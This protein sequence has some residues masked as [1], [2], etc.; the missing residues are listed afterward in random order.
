M[1][2]GTLDGNSAVWN[3]FRIIGSWG[4]NSTALSLQSITLKHHFY[5]TSN[6]ATKEGTHY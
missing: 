2:L 3:D 4:S 6:T 1:D 5:V